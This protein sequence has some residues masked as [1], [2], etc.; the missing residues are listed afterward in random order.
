M[1]NSIPLINHISPNHQSPVIFSYQVFNYINYP[2]PIRPHQFIPQV[3][4]ESQNQARQ[5][6]QIEI[7]SQ[8]SRNKRP[9][10]P[11]LNLGS[12]KN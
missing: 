9:T 5:E 3:I 12:L 4:N 8:V 6:P 7:G 1:P 10:I 2:N 11:N